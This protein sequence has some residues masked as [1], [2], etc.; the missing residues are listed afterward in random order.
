MP[1]KDT[2]GIEKTKDSSSILQNMKN[3]DIIDQINTKMG[4]NLHHHLINIKVKKIEI[5][6]MKGKNTEEGTI[7]KILV[8]INH[9][10]I[11]TR[12]KIVLLMEITKGIMEILIKIINMEIFKT[13]MIEILIQILPMEILN[14]KMG[15]YI[16]NKIIIIEI[17][18][19]TT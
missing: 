9:I 6:L 1:V 16:L 3:V 15:I 13:I 5:N 14:T 10:N 19:K 17:L 8:E 4:H 2:I 7:S 18:S 11:L 12:I